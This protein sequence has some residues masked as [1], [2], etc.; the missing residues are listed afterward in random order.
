M[1]VQGLQTPWAPLPADRNHGGLW[2]HLQHLQHVLDYVQFL[3][4]TFTQNEFWG[5]CSLWRDVHHMSRLFLRVYKMFDLAEHPSPRGWQACRTLKMGWVSH[6]YLYQ[7]SHPQRAQARAGI[8]PWI[9]PST[10]S[11]VVPASWGGHGVFLTHFHRKFCF[12]FPPPL[13]YFLGY[14]LVF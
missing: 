5:Q 4:S 7:A 14:D 1:T 8:S 6:C 10:Q 13:S 12:L 9:S 11:P 3:C 2:L